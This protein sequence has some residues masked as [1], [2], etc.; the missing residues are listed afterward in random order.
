MAKA[1]KKSAK[2]T[3]SD[4]SSADPNAP[5][6][7]SRRGPE[8]GAEV[9]STGGRGAAGAKPGGAKVAKSAPKEFRARDAKIVTKLEDAPDPE[10]YE[11]EDISTDEMKPQNPEWHEGADPRAGP[12]APSETASESGGTSA[13]PDEPLDEEKVNSMSGADLRA[14]AFQRGLDIGPEGGAKYTRRRFLAAQ[15]KQSSVT[16]KKSA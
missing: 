11:G 8:R 13:D 14:V 2:S 12:F 6:L 16:R 10:P 9:P 4:S 15:E 1:A 7:S 3:K 5:D